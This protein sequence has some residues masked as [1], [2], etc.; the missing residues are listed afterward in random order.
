[1]QEPRV[2]S[3][4]QKD[5]LEKEIATHYTI[6]PWKIP[7]T[8]K[9]GGLQSRGSQRVL[10]ESQRVPQDLVT[11]QQTT[12]CLET[13]TGSLKPIWWNLN[14]PCPVFQP[15]SFLLIS[16]YF[17]I[18][19]LLL[20]FLLLWNTSSF[21]T[22]THSMVCT[23]AFGSLTL[24]PFIFYKACRGPAPADP[25]YS[26]ERQRRRPIQMLIRDNKE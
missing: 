6:L 1:M 20:A 24:R 14:S 16:C 5:L 2:Q 26:K 9:P 23:S 10:R 4:I 17:L 13:F 22:H 12:M 7:W 8:E 21:S 15:L 11:E 25:G 19:L 18:V 3:L